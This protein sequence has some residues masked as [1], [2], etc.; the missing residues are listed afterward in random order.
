MTGTYRDRQELN[1][2]LG[3]FLALLEPLDGGQSHVERAFLLGLF[4]VD[5]G[6]LGLVPD[7]EQGAGAV[8]TFHGLDFSA[9]TGR[10]DFPPPTT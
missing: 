5:H 8:T 9:R 10:E 2:L 7:R 3:E 1:G 6:P 4:A